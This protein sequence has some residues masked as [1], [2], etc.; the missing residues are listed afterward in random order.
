[1]KA[2]GINSTGLQRDKYKAVWCQNKL[3]GQATANPI[4]RILV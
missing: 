3:T 4:H 1:V 2:S